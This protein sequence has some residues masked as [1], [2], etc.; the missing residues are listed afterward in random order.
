[1]GK[2]VSYLGEES[3]NICLKISANNS[4]RRKREKETLS[5]KTKLRLKLETEKI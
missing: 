3:L 5:A 1:M 2:W 4:E